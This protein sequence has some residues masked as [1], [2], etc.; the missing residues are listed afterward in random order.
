M[1]YGYLNYQ[2]GQKTTP[3]GSKRFF[4]RDIT[5]LVD[6]ESHPQ[7]LVSKEGHPLRFGLKSTGRDAKKVKE[8]GELLETQKASKEPKASRLRTSQVKPNALQFYKALFENQRSLHRRNHT[9]DKD[10]GFR[11]DREEIRAAERAL[12]KGSRIKVAKEGEAVDTKEGAQERAPSQT[13]QNQE[14]KHNLSRFMKVKRRA[15]TTGNEKLSQER[16]LTLKEYCRSKEKLTEVVDMGRVPSSTKEGRRIS[17]NRYSSMLNVGS[18]GGLSK[19]IVGRPGQFKNGGGSSGLLGSKSNALLNTNQPQVQPFSIETQN[20]KPAKPSMI[21]E[22]FQNLCLN[23][24]DQRADL[25]S[26]M[27]EEKL[28]SQKAGKKMNRELSEKIAPEPKMEEEAQVDPSDQI[29]THY[30]SSSFPGDCKAVVPFIWEHLLDTD[31]RA[32]PNLS[33]TPA[34][35]PVSTTILA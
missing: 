26:K 8:G 7:T 4:G 10:N 1:D 18:S 19:S 33:Q 6:N 3:S 2:N 12:S 14:V 15:P 22:K 13:H 17:G 29:P 20:S 23:L 16:Q 31:V 5:N 9:R 21:K 30:I 34:L 11:E 32:L 28:L 35:P 24:E 25:S 27:N